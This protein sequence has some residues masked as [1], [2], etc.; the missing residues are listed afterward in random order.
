[1]AGGGSLVGQASAQPTIP[2]AFVILLVDIAAIIA[3]LFVVAGIGVIWGLSKRAFDT[4]M[5]GTLT[6]NF[7]VPCLIFSTLTKL[8]VSPAAFGAI[9]GIFSLAILVN[10]M[11][12]AVALRIMRFDVP[13]YLPGAVFANNGN[14]GL[15]LCL[16]AF[17]DEGLALGISVLVVSAVANF[18]IGMALVSGRFSPMEIARTPTIYVV[19]GALLFLG[20][21]V[22]PPAWL[23]NTTQMIGGLS[24]PLMLI[25]LGVS[26]SRLRVRSI[27]RSLLLAVLRIGIGFATGLLFAWLFGLEGA[28]RGVLILQCSMP[29]AVINYIIAARFDRAA[30]DIA[31]LIVASTVISFATLPLLLYVVL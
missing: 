31:G 20:A 28:A 17:G 6:V 12:A 26:L 11:V 14:L 19:A 5:I 10:M 22:E 25:A 1:M 7:G 3:P 15:P 13:A 29:A 21:D 24:I 23:A 18:T 30:G 4:N 16:F 8:Q 27:H 9:A 2:D